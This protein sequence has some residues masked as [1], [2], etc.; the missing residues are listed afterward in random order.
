MVIGSCFCFDFRFSASQIAPDDIKQT[1]PAGSRDAPA[2][3]PR[4]RRAT[5]KRTSG[6]EGRNA[7]SGSLEL[8]VN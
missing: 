3:S 5:R 4:E 2:V 8:M 6:V 1:K 7:F